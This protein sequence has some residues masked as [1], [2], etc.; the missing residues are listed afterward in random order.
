MIDRWWR[1]L[2]DSVKLSYARDRLVESYFWSCAIFHGEKYSRSRII[3]TKVFQLMTLM[4]DTYDIH[5]TLEECYKLN[6]A[7]QR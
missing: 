5:A 4:D 2:Y 6:E 3:F 7:M 1:Q